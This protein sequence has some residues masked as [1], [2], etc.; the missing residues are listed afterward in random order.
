[1]TRVRI[2]LRTATI[3]LRAT[4]GIRNPVHITLRRS[5]HSDQLAARIATRLGNTLNNPEK[6]SMAHPGLNLCL[7]DVFASPILLN[8][9]VE[10]KTSRYKT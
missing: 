9:L 8:N 4:L 1:M 7:I 10:S 3:R 2:R 5:T 6:D